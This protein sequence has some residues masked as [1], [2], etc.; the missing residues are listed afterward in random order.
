MAPDKFLDIFFFVTPLIFI[1]ITYSYLER[2]DPIFKANFICIFFI[3][4]VI[5]FVL[6]F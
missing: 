2:K 5:D 6:Y 4:F 3:I 1:C